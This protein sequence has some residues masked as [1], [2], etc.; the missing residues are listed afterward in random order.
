LADGIETFFINIDDDDWPLRCI[1]G[2][3]YLEKVEDADT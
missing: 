2:V 3:Q 1:T